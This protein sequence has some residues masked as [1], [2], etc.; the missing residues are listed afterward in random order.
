MMGSDAIYNDSGRTVAAARLDRGHT[1]LGFY[2]MKDYDLAKL[3][4]WMDHTPGGQ[5]HLHGWRS[6][7][8]FAF[9]FQHPYDAVIFALT[10]R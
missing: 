4:Q 6:T 3:F 1:D 9:R 2:R 8:G 10:W 7:E 5:Y